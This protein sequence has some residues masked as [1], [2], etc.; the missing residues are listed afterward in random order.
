MT[1]YDDF[2]ELANAHRQFGRNHAYA[3]LRLAVGKIMQRAYTGDGGKEMRYCS[4]CGGVKDTPHGR[5]CIYAILETA[6]QE[7]DELATAPKFDMPIEVVKQGTNSEFRYIV[8]DALL[9]ALVENPRLSYIEIVA[10]ESIT[11]TASFDVE[12]VT[13]TLD[14]TREPAPPGPYHRHTH[15]LPYNVVK[16]VY[17]AMTIS[18]APEIS[19]HEYPEGTQDYYDSQRVHEMQTFDTDGTLTPVTDRQRVGE[20]GYA[21][22]QGYYLKWNAETNVAILWVIKAAS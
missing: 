8:P 13:A 19:I 2:F 22:L 6:V 21:L 1:T 12:P 7:G 11:Y 16:A 3:R 18:R 10:G 14:T 4:Y 9:K 15:H 20:T 17:E 5:D